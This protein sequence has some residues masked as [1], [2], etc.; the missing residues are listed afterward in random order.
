[1]ILRAKTRVRVWLPAGGYVRR[2]RQTSGCKISVVRASAGVTVR[3]RA[4]GRFT[5]KGF[6]LV[7]R[8]ALAG[9]WAL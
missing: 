9:N 2:R 6:I 3:Y 8:E 5:E 4:I 1:M 7:T